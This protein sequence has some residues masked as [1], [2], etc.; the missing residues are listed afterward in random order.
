[1]SDYELGRQIAQRGNFLNPSAPEEM[2]RGYNDELDSIQQQ[3]QKY[4][5]AQQQA[6]QAS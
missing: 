4:R 5:N 3:E 1:M 2:R 6:S